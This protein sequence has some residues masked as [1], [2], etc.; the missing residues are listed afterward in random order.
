L[1]PRRAPGLA[2]RPLRGRVGGSGC[3]TLRCKCSEIVPLSLVTSEDARKPAWMTRR[4]MRVT[5]CVQTLPNSNART[6]GASTWMMKTAASTRMPST[7]VNASRRAASLIVRRRSA[8]AA[9]RLRPGRLPWQVT[10]RP[11]GNETPPSDRP[12]LGVLRQAAG[13]VINGRQ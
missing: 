12:V 5:P 2:P 10:S 13:L 7:A 4:T 3:N 11:S 9:T 6:L 8:D 1:P